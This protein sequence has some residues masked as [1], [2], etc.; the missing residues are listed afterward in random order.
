MQKVRVN[1]KAFSSKLLDNTVK[2]ILSVVRKNGSNTLGPIPLP[3]RIEKYCVLRSPHVNKKSREQFEM[4][5]HKRILY[6][7]NT[8][9]QTMDALM[10]VEV[11][12]GVDLNIKIV[13]N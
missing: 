11:S 7:T 3:T 6:I 5:T 2:D 12:T 9:P 4:R 13:N 8:S 10:K 1:L